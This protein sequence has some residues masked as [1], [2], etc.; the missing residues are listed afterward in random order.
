M[1]GMDNDYKVRV[2]VDKITDVYVTLP[3]HIKGLTA[4][5]NSIPEEFRDHTII[6]M[7][8][9]YDYGDKYYYL[10]IYYYRKENEQ[11]KKLRLKEAKGLKLQRRYEYERLKKEFENED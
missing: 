9:D 8:Q 4:T 7:S 1:N 5:L 10:E 2:D 3:E 11:E 6:E